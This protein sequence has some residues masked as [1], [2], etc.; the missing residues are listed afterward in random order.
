MRQVLF[1]KMAELLPA[2]LSMARAFVGGG[3]LD[4]PRT[5]R[6]QKTPGSLEPGVFMYLS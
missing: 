6:Q 4:A 1:V 5:M 3:V 2:N